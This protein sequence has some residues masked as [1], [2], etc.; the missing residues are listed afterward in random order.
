MTFRNCTYISIV[1]F[2]YKNNHTPQRAQSLAILLHAW[3]CGCN[4]G[5]FGNLFSESYIVNHGWNTNGLRPTKSTNVAFFQSAEDVSVFPSFWCSNLPHKMGPDSSEKWSDKWPIQWMGFA[6]TRTGKLTL[7]SWKITIFDRRY[8]FIH[9]WFSIVIPKNPD[10][11]KVAILR[12]NTP[13]RHTGSFTLPLEGPWGFL[14]LLVF[15][16][17]LMGFG[18][19]LQELLNLSDGTSIRIA[20]TPGMGDKAGWVLGRRFEPQNWWEKIT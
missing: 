17:F 13:L 8:I 16:G 20:R 6:Q 15:Q 5:C 18:P 9:G 14:G 7:T 2:L 19:T 3:Q 1:P 4:T 10:P 12:T 11:S